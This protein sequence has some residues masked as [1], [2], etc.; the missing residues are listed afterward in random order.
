MKVIPSYL[1]ATSVLIAGMD[2]PCVRAG[3]LF[4]SLFS[5]NG[6]NGANPVAAL[7]QGAD[8]NFYGTA[9]AGG[10]N[11]TGTVFRISPEGSAFTN[12]YFFTGD[13]N[14]AIPSGGLAQAADGTFFGTTFGGGASNCGTVFRIT[15]SGTLASL[16]SFANTNG[17]GPSATMAEADD[18][19]FYGSTDYGGP[20]YTNATSGGSGY[21]VI[22]RVTPNGA[23]TTPAWFGSTNGAN[24]RGLVPG[25]D[26]N[27]Y[28]TTA[29]GGNTSLLRLGFGT[30]FKLAPDGTLTNLYLFSGFD[31]GGFVYAGLVQGI[32]GYL[33]G[34]TF[35]GGSAGYGTLFRISTN[36]QFASLHSFAGGIDGANPAGPLVQGSDGKLYGTTYTR[37]TY[38][39][40]TV[41]Q[42]DPNDGTGATLI[43]FT[44]TTGS[45]LGANPSGRL[46]VGDDGNFYGVTPNGGSYNAGTIFRI[47]VPMPPLLQSVSKTNGSLS[48]VWSAVA[49]QSYQVQY[50]TDL[51]VTNWNNFGSSFTATNGTVRVSDPIGPDRQRF[52]RLALLP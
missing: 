36:G 19:S 24:P 13:T 50:T 11:N 1:L 23:F 17:A 27:F 22:Y 26:G 14:G 38:G 31:D 9:T 30:V 48:I 10:I 35:S 3:I 43:S 52:Y 7:V 15:A 34:A 37:G 46:V 42:F 40:G 45:Y 41:F 4:G 8:R 18:G 5:F 49:G 44:G 51:T 32:D 39:Y 6:T 2:V 29:W 20:Y 12:L 47:S 21:G 25:R 16:A 28:G 33:Y